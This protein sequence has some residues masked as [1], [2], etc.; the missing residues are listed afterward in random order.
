L[1]VKG[2]PQVSTTPVAN[3][4]TGTAGVVDTGGKFVA[5]VNDTDSK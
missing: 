4:S 1:K 3:F 2:A 5:S